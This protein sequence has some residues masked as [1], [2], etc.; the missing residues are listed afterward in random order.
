MPK[1]ISAGRYEMKRYYLPSNFIIDTGSRVY[2]FQQESLFRPCGTVNWNEEIAIPEY[3]NL[4]PK[5]L[6]EIPPNSIEEFIK[7]NILSNGDWKKNVFISSPMDTV[8]SRSLS[9]IMKIFKDTTK[10]IEWNFRKTTQEENFVIEY[11]KRPYSYYP[12]D[13]L[14]W[15]STKTLFPEMINRII[16]EN[17]N[18]QLHAYDKFYPSKKS[19]RNFNKLMYSTSDSASFEKLARMLKIKVDDL[20]TFEL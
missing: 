7:L 2:F 3:I 15:D 8:S 14:K 4:K 20:F 1:K 11:K 6:I 9:R 16:D 12:P 5:D 17:I 19:N 18:T 13:N 10:H